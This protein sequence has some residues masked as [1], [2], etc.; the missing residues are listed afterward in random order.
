[1]DVVSLFSGV[2]G[3]DLGFER[4]GMTTRLLCEIDKHAR[5]VL[6]HRFPGVPIHPDVTELTADD[7]RAA[8]AVPSRTVL[9]AGF[10]CQDLSV[11]GARRGMG[12]ESGTRSAL[13]WQVDRIL[14]EFRPAWVVLENVPGLLSSHGGRDMGA[15]LGA[16]ADRGYG[17]AYR[18]LDA[19]FFGVPQRRRRVVIVG[20]LGDSGAAPARVLLEPEGGDWDSAAGVTSGEVPA[21]R[22]ARGVVAAL[23]ASGVGTCGADDNQAQAGHL[24]A[25]DPKAGGDST[26][27]GAF[28]DGTGITPTLG[29]S[30]P[31][32]VAQTFQKV[33]RSGARDA[34][35]NLLFEVWEPRDVAATL[36]LHDLGSDTRAVE[37]VVCATGDVTHT[38]TAEGHDASEDGTG[39][40]TPIIAATLTAGTSR[41][42]VSAPGRRQEDDINLV[43]SETTVRRLTPLECE[44]LQ[45][46]P[47]GWTDVDG[48]SDSQ[49]YRQMGNSVTVT[50]FEWVGRRLL[51]ED[52]RA[53]RAA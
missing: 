21:A 27:S 46:Y 50:V 42:G 5:A 30:R 38:L 47:D 24:I 29:G 20:R 11:A 34:D 53:R 15:V 28:E 44:R 6:A 7:L 52:T 2:G 9:V 26:S 37:L 4:A 10:P 40:G 3:I 23:S 48:M 16:L 25:F 49:R 8:G 35:G 18:V 33:I 41:P 14:A 39:R 13:F 31:H 36:N 43:P 45:G 1:M 19:Q 51:A 32:A 17:F 12:R 22:A